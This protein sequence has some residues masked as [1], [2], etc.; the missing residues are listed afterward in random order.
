MKVN[1]SCRGNHKEAERLDRDPQ[2]NAKH[3]PFLQPAPSRPNTV[4]YHLI[5][6]LLLLLSFSPACPALLA[7]IW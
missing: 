2:T 4:L 1:E 6:L 7:F 5:L 3:R